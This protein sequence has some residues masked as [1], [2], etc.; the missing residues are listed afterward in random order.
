MSWELEKSISQ[1][2]LLTFE[3]IIGS[4]I[5]LNYAGDVTMRLAQSDIP[6]LLCA[7]GGTGKEVFAYAIH[8]ASHKR[9]YPFIRV[10]CTSIPDEP[11][12]SNL[13]D[14]DA[15][16]FTGASKPKKQLKLEFAHK[17]TIFLDDIGDLPLGL[18][19]KLIRILQEKEIE[20][21]SASR[22]K[23]IDFRL[24]AATKKDLDERVRKG[25]FRRDLFSCLKVITV[26]LPPLREIK[27]DIPILAEHF[28]MKLRRRI[29]SDVEEIAPHNH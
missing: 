12:K 11:F 28:L 9:D 26:T 8:Q 1:D 19:A 7:E 20:P 23:M 17:G 6:I 10:D 24:I 15:G 4:S 3:D 2:T 21:L 16:A 25:Q 5:R 14:C 13:F 22:P 27:E 18:Q 29:R